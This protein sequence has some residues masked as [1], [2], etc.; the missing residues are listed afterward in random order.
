MTMLEVYSEEG[1]LV[2]RVKVEGDTYQLE[3]LERGVYM[4]RIQRSHDIFVRRII[5]TQ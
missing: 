2:E 5:K 3:G 1:K 4:L